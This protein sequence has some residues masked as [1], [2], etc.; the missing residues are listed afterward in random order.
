MTVY[1]DGP[2]K[3]QLALEPRIFPY[4]RGDV[5]YGLHVHAPLYSPIIGLISPDEVL[6][7]FHPGFLMKDEPFLWS[8]NRAS[9][10][11]CDLQA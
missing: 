8:T 6:R 3:L 10:H 5:L 11:D 7:P 2:I 4:V 1:P 9:A